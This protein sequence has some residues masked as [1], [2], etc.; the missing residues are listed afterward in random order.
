MSYVLGFGYTQ[1]AI[2]GSI[3]FCV[4]LAIQTV[5][6]SHWDMLVPPHNILPS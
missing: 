3:E 5:I 4:V 6:R 1:Q 2:K